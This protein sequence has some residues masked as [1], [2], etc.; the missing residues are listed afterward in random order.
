MMFC[1]ELVRFSGE[2]ADTGYFASSQFGD[3]CGVGSEELV[4]GV[5]GLVSVQ[6]P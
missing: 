1:F 4:D 5:E 2:L 3:H 6:R